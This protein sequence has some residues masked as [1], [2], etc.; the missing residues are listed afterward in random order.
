VPLGHGCKQSQAKVGAN[1]DV[2]RF[3]Q[4]RHIL[5]PAM[6]RRVGDVDGDVPLEEFAAV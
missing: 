5:E 1:V 4:V 3:Y 6:T 2:G